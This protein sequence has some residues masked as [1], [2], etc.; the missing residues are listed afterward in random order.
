VSEALNVN[1]TSSKVNAKSRVYCYG[2]QKRE[3][4][5]ARTPWICSTPA[6]FIVSEEEM[7]EKYECAEHPIIVQLQYASEP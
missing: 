2:L 1:E 6:C 4:W 3:K 5:M 7:V